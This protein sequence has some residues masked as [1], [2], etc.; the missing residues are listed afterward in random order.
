MLSLLSVT[1]LKAA[2]CPTYLHR[3]RLL[4]LTN[5]KNLCVG[6]QYPVYNECYNLV[7]VKHQQS[8]YNAVNLNFIGFVVVALYLV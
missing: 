8:H 5:Q 4:G 1:T 7:L 3:K 2:S 6:G